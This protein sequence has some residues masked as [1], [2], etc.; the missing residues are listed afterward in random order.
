MGD[1]NL[2]LHPHEEDEDEK[3]ERG[4]L[5]ERPRCVGEVDVMI[6]QEK[7][8]G[9]GLGKAAVATFLHHVLGHADA[10]LGE[11]GAAQKRA[12]DDDDDGAGPELTMLMA[13]IHKDNGA[14]IALFKGLGFAQ[15]GGVD[16]FGEIKL[17]L[18]A[19]ETLR[20]SVPP[21]YRELVY[22]GQRTCLLK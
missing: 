19:F 18:C 22:T 9:R 21:G 5:P 16:Y 17:V 14:S 4:G 20:E 10:I 1:I 11:Y 13:K 7:D 8:R 15:R 6:A 12:G 2:F 3:G